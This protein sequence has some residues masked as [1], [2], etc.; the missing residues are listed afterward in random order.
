MSRTKGTALPIAYVTLR[1]LTILNW[2]Y[3]AAKEKITV[4]PCGVD[5]RLFSPRN[6]HEAHRRLSLPCGRLLLFVGR[7][8][9]LKG[10]DTLLEATAQLVL[11]DIVSVVSPQTW[12][13]NGSNWERTR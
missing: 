2:L 10:I 11:L 6:Q 13:W 5:G 4:I 12:I 1:I 9:R 7:I 3:G 8:E